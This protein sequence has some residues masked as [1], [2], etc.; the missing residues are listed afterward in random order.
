MKYA[1]ILTGGKQYKVSEGDIISVD[2]LEGKKDEKIN[3]EQVLLV[4]DDGKISLGKPELKNVKVLGKIIDQF[5]GEKVRVSKFKSK[6]RVRRAMG[7]RAQLTKVQIEKIGSGKEEK[8]E[9][10]K[11]TKKTK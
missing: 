3:F 6:V 4:A 1:V 2:K 9:A 8:K 10:V 11:T 5:K 7:F